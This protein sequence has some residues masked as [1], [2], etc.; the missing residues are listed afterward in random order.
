[1]TPTDRNT[2]HGDADLS[3]TTEVDLTQDIATVAG[4]FP[5]Q[6]VTLS[7]RSDEVVLTCDGTVVQGRIRR[8][9]PSPRLHLSPELHEAVFGDTSPLSGVSRGSVM[10][11]IAKRADVLFDAH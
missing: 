6:A 9:D 1:M 7:F 11:A 8:D 4:D 5:E 10:H 3:T 2:P